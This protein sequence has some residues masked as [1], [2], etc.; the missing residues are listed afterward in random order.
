[1]DGLLYNVSGFVGIWLIIGAYF[2]MNAGKWRDDAPRFHGCNLAGALLILVS[3]IH[4]WNLPVF[5][6]EV[7]WSS[8]AAYGLWQALKRPKL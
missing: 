3:L 8:V 2:M 1:M 4:A 6:M 5:V 7:A